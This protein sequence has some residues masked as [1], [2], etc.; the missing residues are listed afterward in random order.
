MIYKGTLQYKHSALNNREILFG[1]ISA[2]WL[3]I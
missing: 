1:Y 2:K 3:L